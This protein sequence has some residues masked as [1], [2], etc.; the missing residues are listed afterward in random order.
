MIKRLII[1]IIALTLV[2][3]GIVGYNIFVGKMIAQFFAGMKP[4]PVAVSVTE[5][6]PGRWE[7][8]ID[9]IGTAAALRGTDL[10]VEASGIVREVLFAAN[11]EVKA[12]QV[13]VQIDDRQ[14]R[15]D[16][17]A[18]KAGA[19]LAETALK[20]ARELREKGVSATSSL[21]QAEAAAIEARATVAKI[22]AA[23]NTKRITAP[24]DGTIGIP[25]IELGSFVAAGTPFATLQDR[26]AM[27][28]DFTLTE[29]Q[30]AQVAPG[31]TVGLR[32]EVGDVQLEGTITGIEPRID[33]NSRLVT[34]RAE[35]PEAGEQ[36]TPGQFL[37]LRVRLPAEEGVIALPQTAVSSTLYGDSVYVVREE[38]P[39]GAEAP[40]LVAKQVFVKIGRRS[41]ESIEI[42]EG[43]KAGD[44]VVNAGQ[45]KLSSGATVSVDNA[46][47]P[48]AA[49]AARN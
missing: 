31:M 5:V 22:E 16:L 9:T 35:V 47:S 20:R 2:A 11:E 19:D 13:L 39:E 8:G 32:S 41:G 6:V 46:L 27:R 18:A 45:N 3:G 12:G 26:S 4:A 15:A 48:D 33:P 10:A 36:L 38:T 34:L 25:Q 30:A 37:R 24:F 28:V 42:V 43:L 40:V 49:P 29:Q 21:D 44:R 1:A 14:E 7:P 23:L 17:A